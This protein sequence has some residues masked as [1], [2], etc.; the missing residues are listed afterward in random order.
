MDVADALPGRHPWDQAAVIVS[1]SPCDCV[2][3][4]VGAAR[5]GRV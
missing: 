4:L 2:S 5:A 3:K 1:W